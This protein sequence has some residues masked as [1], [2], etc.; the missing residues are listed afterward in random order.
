VLS[1]GTG[2]LY[3]KISAFCVHTV[4][5][6]L[7]LSLMII[8]RYFYAAFTGKVFGGLGGGACFGGVCVSRGG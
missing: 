7:P 3:I 1:I 4:L 8:G 5:D 6:A 2:G